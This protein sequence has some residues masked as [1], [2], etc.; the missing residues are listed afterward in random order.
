MCESHYFVRWILIAL[1]SFSVLLKFNYLGEI[2]EGFIIL[3][4]FILKNI[5]FFNGFLYIFYTF[6]VVTFRNRNPE[7]M[8]R[9][10]ER[11]TAGTIMLLLVYIF[12]F[13]QMVL[14][15]FLVMLVETFV[16]GVIYG[17]QYIRNRWITHV[18]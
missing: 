12:W 3:F 16:L 17:I 1:L 6:I 2:W 11:A 9:S 18:Y 5:I 8:I 10:F 15:L 7:R 4:C 14:D 13:Y